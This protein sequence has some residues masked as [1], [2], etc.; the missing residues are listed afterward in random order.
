MPRSY[1]YSEAVPLGQNELHLKPRNTGQQTC[2]DHR[3]V[4][5]PHPHK[6]EECRDYFGNL[7]HFFTIQDQHYELSVASHSE[8]ELRVGSVRAAR[9]DAGLGTS[10]AIAAAGHRRR[11]GRVAVLV[12]FG[13]RGDQCRRWPNLP[14]DR[15]R[16]GGPGWTRRST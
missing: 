2:L 7:I 3:L 15:L 10:G 16:P 5:S 14:G 11:A 4:I 6:L 12:R 8:V 9:T 1:L 13:P